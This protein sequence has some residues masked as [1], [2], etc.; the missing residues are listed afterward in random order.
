MAGAISKLF[1]VLLRL[2][3]KKG[4]LKRQFRRNSFNVFSLPIPPGRIFWKYNIDTYQINNRNV[5]TIHP[6]I[7]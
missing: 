5:F 7:K 2:I 4:L 1:N 3:N 6:N